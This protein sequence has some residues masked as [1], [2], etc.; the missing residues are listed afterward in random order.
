MKCKMVVI[1]IYLPLINSL[2]DYGEKKERTSPLEKNPTVKTEPSSKGKI[3]Y[4]I[5]IV[6]CIACK[7]VF[8]VYA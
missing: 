8:Y 7:T 5:L 4:I 3:K 2:K 6:D 1:V